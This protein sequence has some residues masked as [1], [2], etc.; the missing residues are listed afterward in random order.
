[1]TDQEDEE[2]TAFGGLFDAGQELVNGGQRNVFALL[3][4]DDDL[5]AVD[6]HEI[7]LL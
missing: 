5:H 7:K 3:E 4:G 6:L 2:G 1:M